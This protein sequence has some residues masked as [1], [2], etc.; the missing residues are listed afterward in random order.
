MQTP[1]S[2]EEFYLN[3]RAINTPGTIDIHVGDFVTDAYLLHVKRAAANDPRPQRYF[4]CDG[5]YLRHQ[6]KSMMESLSKMSACWAP[7]DSLQIFSDSTS[8]IVQFAA[9][10]PPRSATW[11][12]R[13]TKARYDDQSK[14]VSIRI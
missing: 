14:L 8:A 10:V 5:S 7:G 3:L 11:N 4:V 1:D 13:P 12:D 2:V 6:G 9:D